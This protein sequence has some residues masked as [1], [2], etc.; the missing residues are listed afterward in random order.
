M[1]GLPNA[2]V[3]VV[4]L[5]SRDKVFFQQ[6]KSFETASIKLGCSFVCCDAADKFLIRWP[7]VGDDLD[8]FQ[9]LETIWAINDVDQRV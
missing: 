7:H 9:S 1:K 2:Q 4:A 3:D 5:F 8:G 6:K